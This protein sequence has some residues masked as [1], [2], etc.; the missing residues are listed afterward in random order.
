MPPPH[1]KTAPWLAPAVFAGA[2]VPLANLVFRAARGTLG[3]DPVAIALNQLGLLALTFLLLSLACTPIKILSGSPLPIRPRKMLGLFAFFYA[4]CHFMT[5][6]VVDQGL[7]VAAILEDIADRKFIFVGFAALILLVPLAITSTAKMLKRLGFA[8]W[9]RL[10][11]L[12]Y[13]AASLGAIHFYLRVKKDVTE[14]TVYAVILGVLFAIRIGS[15][16]WARYAGKHA[17]G[18]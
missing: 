17:H 13:L 14:P 10:H 15:V 18:A 11:R 8:R 3:A 7:D 16:A 1:G 12:V 2:L 6:A 4:A 9:K 5:Y